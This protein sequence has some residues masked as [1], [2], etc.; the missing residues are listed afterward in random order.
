MPARKAAKRAAA[1]PAKSHKPAKIIKQKNAEILLNPDLRTYQHGG[2]VLAVGQ[3][4]VGQLGL[5]TEYMEKMRPA[6]VP[7]CQ[8]IVCIAAGGMHSVCLTKDGTVLTFGCNDEGALGRDTSVEDSETTPALVQLDGKAIQVTAGDSHSAALLEDGRAFAWGS[9]R[10]SHG[11]MGLTLKGNERIPVQMLPREKIVK[12]A[13]GADHLIFLTDH[14]QVY[15]CGCAEQGQL[16]RICPRSADRHGRRGVAPLLTPRLVQFNRSK[17]S[18]AEDIWAGSYCTF[19]KIHDTE[20]IHVFGLNNYHQLGLSETGTQA[21]PCKSET[22]DGR[23][24]KHISSG[25]HHTLALDE[26]GQ[27]FVLGRKEYGRLGLGDTCEDAKELTLVPSLADLKCIDVAAGSAQS[28]AVTEKG[29][30]YA[31]GMG[32]N[33]QLG[34]GEEDDVSIPTVIRGKSW[35]KD[36]K[37]VVRVV[38]GGQHTLILAGS[39]EM[40]EE[41][42]SPPS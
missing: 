19:V 4:D 21:F 24:W 42:V 25:Q 18:R 13:S 27:V 1:L 23:K 12:I 32:S 39:P 10:D 35:M 11:N 2:M 15:T 16:G 14:G 38:G 26:T 6:A 3:G 22:F 33:G 40:K 37:V 41:P 34:T 28:F 31:W 7:G 20:N 17:H 36:N 30:L 5:G 29:D 9:F 8:D